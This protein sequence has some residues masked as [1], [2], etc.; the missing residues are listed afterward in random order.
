MGKAPR[1]GTAGFRDLSTHMHY[2][3]EIPIQIAFRVGAF[4]AVLNKTSPSLSLGV[5]VSASHNK[6]ED[7]GVKIANFG[8]H[9][10]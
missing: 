3:I 4:V 6:I 5:V 9:M 10:L 8:G 2:V 7:N 1:Y